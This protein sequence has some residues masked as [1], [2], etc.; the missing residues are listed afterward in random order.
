MKDK[1]NIDELLNGYIDDELSP[2]QHTEVNRLIKHDSQ[3]A[4]KLQQL[5]MCKTLLSALPNEDTP[6]DLLEDIKNALERK[7]LLQ[8]TPK[9]FQKNK[10]VKHLH[11]KK[12]LASAAMIAMFAALGTI[13]YSII[14]PSKSDSASGNW[15]NL[16]KTVASNLSN[17]PVKPKA[18]AKPQ[19][20][21]ASIELKT[22][23]FVAT[24]AFIKKSLEEN[25]LLNK[26]APVNDGASGL[27]YV[28]SNMTDANL[29]LADMGHIGQRFK[30]IDLKITSPDNK[31]SSSVK[32]LSFSQIH[33]IINQTTFD[34]SKKVASQIAALNYANYS[35]PE[36]VLAAAF[37]KTPQSF[38]IPKPVLTAGSKTPKESANKDN[39]KNKIYLTIKLIPAK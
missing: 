7:T 35:Q 38:T 21:I 30:S 4:E 13:I 3:I 25:G 23:A 12:I 34:E 16:T 32:N 2:R 14:G 9:H 18:A 39:D 17:K 24:N 27:Y 5:K 31:S 26:N 28:K 19:N 22:D 10:G 36:N 20:I 29:L 37:E 33:Q 15:K 8:E 1:D 6:Y 11:F